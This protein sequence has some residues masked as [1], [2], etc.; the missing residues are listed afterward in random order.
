MI[1][2]TLATAI[3]FA[4]V[5]TAVPVFATTSTNSN[6]TP[7]E[8]AI[9]QQKKLEEK[10]GESQKKLQERFEE[11]KRKLQERLT[12][13][14]NRRAN[15]AAAI[16]CVAVAVNNR[17]SA[18]SAAWN[19][20]S[21]SQGAALAAR[22]SALNTAWTSTTTPAVVR[23]AVNAAWSEYRKAHGLAVSAHNSSTRAAWNTFKQAA[24]TCKASTNG[25]SAES[26]GSGVDTA[27]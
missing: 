1:K 4:S 5:A 13:A 17:E 16:A 15:Q 22:A 11:A 2:N 7:E 24:K 18:V 8:W 26:R 19:T 3:I 20:Y 27:Q 23:T 10:F 12:T 9:Q 14:Q 6:L 25:V 21:A